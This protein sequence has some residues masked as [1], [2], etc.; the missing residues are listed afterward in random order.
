[1]QRHYRYSRKILPRF[2]QELQNKINRTTHTKT[3]NSGYHWLFE[4]QRKDFPKGIVQKQYWKDNKQ[5]E[6]GEIKVIGTNLY[7]IERGFGYESIR[8]IE[9]S[10]ILT[11]DETNELL[12]KLDT[13]EG[14]NFWH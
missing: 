13:F 5:H 12:A 3:A 1:V 10:V 4:I 8:G 7:L 2:S 14:I 11:K 6:H 9:S